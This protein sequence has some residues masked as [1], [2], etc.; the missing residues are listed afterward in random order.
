MIPES[1]KLGQTTTEYM[2]LLVVMVTIITSLL[3]YIKNKYLGDIAKCDKAAN[4]K[5]ILCK[6]NGII[7]PK[8]TGKK[9][10]YY[11]FK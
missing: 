3:S 4:Q 7:E 11:R 10:Q 8:G 2:L 1:N 6:I 9:F 5:T